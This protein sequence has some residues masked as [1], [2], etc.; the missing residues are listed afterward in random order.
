MQGRNDRIASLSN[1]NRR[2]AVSRNDQKLVF[3]GRFVPVSVFPGAVL[4]EVLSSHFNEFLGILTG[5][6]TPINDDKMPFKPRFI[7]AY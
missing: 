2:M 3:P 4:L 7:R 1:S 6:P 5:N